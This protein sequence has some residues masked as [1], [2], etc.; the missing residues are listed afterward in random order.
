MDSIVPPRRK[1]QNKDKYQLR[2]M[3]RSLVTNLENF[4]DELLVVLDDMKDLVGQIDDVSNK[5]DKQFGKKWRSEDIL[6]SHSLTKVDILPTEHHYVNIDLRPTIQNIEKKI[7]LKLCSKERN[8]DDKQFQKCDNNECFR[9]QETQYKAN[10]PNSFDKD[11]D[12]P[13]QEAKINIIDNHKLDHVLDSLESPML[14]LSYLGI[15]QT[16]NSPP[17]WGRSISLPIGVKSQVISQEKSPILGNELIVKKNTS[18]EIPERVRTPSAICFAELKRHHVPKRIMCSS[19]SDEVF[20]DTEIKTSTPT[21]GTTVKS[22]TSSSMI[23]N[24]SVDGDLYERK[25]DNELE[26]MFETSDDSLMIESSD[27]SMET[28]SNAHTETYSDNVEGRYDINTWTLFTLNHMTDSTKSSESF[29]S[30]TPSDIMNDNIWPPSNVGD[31]FS[32]SMLA[33][34]LDRHLDND[35][36][37]LHADAKH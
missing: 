36:C 18:Q 26:N 12:G 34:T 1:S 21:T 11:L 4:Q 23:S 20:D 29:V 16:D 33:R 35:F 27:D 9:L 3:V 15:N 8:S 5:L 37:S 2:K 31:I 19:I 13:K 32:N 28:G 6:R 22:L 14:D 10:R 24:V 30:D 25:L 7:N 17:R